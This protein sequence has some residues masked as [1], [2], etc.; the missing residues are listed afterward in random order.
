MFQVTVI[1]KLLVVF[2]MCVLAA[3]A[4]VVEMIM[5]GNL[6]PNQDLEEKLYNSI[7]TGKYDSAVAQSLEHERQN[8]GSVI[9][10]VVNNLI[11]DKRQN[12]IEYCY[13]L[14]VGKGQHILRKYFPLSFQLSM[15]GD[16]VKL[17]YRNYKLAL[18]LSCY[19][20]LNNERIAYGDGKNKDQDVISWK[21][22][23]LW[24][25]N[26]VYFKI[27]NTKYNQYLKMSSKIDCNA[28]DRIAKGSNTADSTSEQWFLQPAMCV[29]AANTS[30]VEMIMDGNLAPNQDLGEKLYNGFSGHF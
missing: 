14:W 12:T 13:K 29:L 4:S 9:Q 11:V 15:T 8:K 19:Y 18:K 30:I 23:T 26:R 10:N 20:Y 22:I 28:R 17:V 21:F 5:D 1:M 6:V 7:F 3:S 24:E 16:F 27:Y 25:D 2:A